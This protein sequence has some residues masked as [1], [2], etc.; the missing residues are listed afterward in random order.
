M[1]RGTYEGDFHGGYDDEPHPSVRRQEYGLLEAAKW[2]GIEGL[3]GIVLLIRV[4]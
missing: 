3:V 1:A 4:N 2:L